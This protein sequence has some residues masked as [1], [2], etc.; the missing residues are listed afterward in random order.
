[1]TLKNEFIKQQ[2]ALRTHPISNTL[3]THETTLANQCYKL[4]SGCRGNTITLPKA[5][6]I[7][8]PP[9]DTNI[10]SLEIHRTLKEHIV[11]SNSTDLQHHAY[12]IYH[13]MHL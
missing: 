3:S 13:N 1:M 4:A 7:N 8:G 10:V 12:A 2:H 9:L 11:M 5:L 6:D